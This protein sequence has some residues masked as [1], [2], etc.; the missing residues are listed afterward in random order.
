MHFCASMTCIIVHV[1]G[2]VNPFRVFLSSRKGGPVYPASAIA[3]RT[4]VRSAS[5]ACCSVRPLVSTC[6]S[7]LE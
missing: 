4:A 1:I 7:A 5:K 3:W 6:R 2:R